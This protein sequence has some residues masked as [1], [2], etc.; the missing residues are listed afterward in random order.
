MCYCATKMLYISDTIR[1]VDIIGTFG[2]LDWLKSR[3][4]RSLFETKTKY[5]KQ[6]N[7]GKW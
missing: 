6:R 4:S 1:T 3:P 5:E 7:D 2:E